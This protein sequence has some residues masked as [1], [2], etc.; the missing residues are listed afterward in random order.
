MRKTLILLALM[1]TA[2][3]STPARA[4]TGMIIIRDTEIEGTLRSWVTPIWQAAGLNPQ[5]TKL[6]LVQSPD[7]NAFVAGGPNIFLYTGMILRAQNPGEILGV[8]AHETGHIADGHLIRGREAM[9]RAS[10]EAMLG[11]ILGIGAGAAGG[12]GAA[13]ALILGGQG[14]AISQ[15]LAHSRVQESSADQ[16]GLRFL[17]AA[18]DSPEGMVT[19]LEKLKSQEL[20][21]Q[22]Q[23]SAYLQT[24][25]LTTD[26]LAAME[27][28]AAKS[29]YLN[30]PYPAAWDDAYKRIQAKLLGFIQPD[31]VAWVY[32][33][34][35][36]S[37]PA[38]YARTIAAYRRSE[39]DK[40]LAGIDALIAHETQNPY[41]Y[42]LK[43][44]MLRD[45]GQLPGA[46]QAYHKA[47]ALKPDAALIRID[48]AQVLVAM[49]GNN[50]D[51]A[52]YREAETQLDAARDKEPRSVDMQRLYAT[53]YGRQGDESR[54]RYHLAEQAVLEG[55][56]REARTLLAGAIGGI[57]PGNKDF[58]AANDLK[59]YLDSQPDKSD[60]KGDRDSR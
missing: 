1:F 39:K 46:A 9:E 53:I 45:F 17:Q 7:F 10:Y 22:S 3:V 58:R 27:A 13:N 44:Q 55:R 14:M 49:A 21:P 52:L 40:A 50:G 32:P 8:L 20:M 34:A 43:G 6:I 60:K 29:P 11:M 28:G 57:K 12:G 38:Q 30:K 26:R 15:F 47:V 23:Q 25:P 5:S 59:L 16:A 33:P 54:A 51:G 56:M 42:E 48:L 31:R 35:D 37:I 24:H 19:L 41:F 4:D 18:G 36:N 2:F